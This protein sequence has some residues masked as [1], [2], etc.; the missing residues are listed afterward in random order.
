[1]VCKRNAIY[2]RNNSSQ[3]KKLSEIYL[4]TSNV[5]LNLH[6]ISQLLENVFRHIILPT[7]PTC[8]SEEHGVIHFLKPV[9]FK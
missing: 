5:D 7:N 6:K 8:I 3:K 2:L 4:T 9:A 1:M